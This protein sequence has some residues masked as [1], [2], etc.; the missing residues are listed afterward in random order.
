MAEL[1]YE[2]IMDYYRCPLKYKFKHELGMK[3]TSRN[4]VKMETERYKNTLRQAAMFY[5]YNIMIGKPPNL[6]QL[7][8]KW[9]KLWNAEDLTPEEIAFKDTG[10]IRRKTPVNYQMLAMK[11]LTKFFDE[12]TK[13]EF[14]PIIVDTDV[15]VQIGRHYVSGTID[16]VREVKTEKGNIIELDRIIST[17]YG[18]QNFLVLNDFNLLFQVY[19]FRKLFEAKED[20]SVEKDIKNGTELRII[21]G[22]NELRKLEAIVN[23]IGDCIDEERFHPQAMHECLMQ[24]PFKQICKNYKF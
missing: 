10:E 16:L 19:A 15:R 24:C 13:K 17:K 7:Q 22:E 12:E 2:K 14:A 9:F 11:A 6:N 18:L 21:I 1:S 4:Q 8:N 3:D 23:N 20:V 5:Y